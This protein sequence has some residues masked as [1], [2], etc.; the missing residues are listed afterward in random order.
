MAVLKILGPADSGGDFLTFARQTVNNT[1]IWGGRTKLRHIL[2]G[3][4]IYSSQK[5]IKTISKIP[6]R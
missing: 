6:V 3:S 4:K 1:L 5:A 2:A